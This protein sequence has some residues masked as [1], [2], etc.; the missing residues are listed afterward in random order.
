MVS[1]EP[2][3]YEY[4]MQRISVAI[5]LGN[6]TSVIGTLPDSATIDLDFVA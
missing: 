6:A 4:P 3:S 2:R 1:G 5:Q